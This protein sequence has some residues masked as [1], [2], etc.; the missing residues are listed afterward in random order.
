VN[1]N[2]R[3]A[4]DTQ[5]A[6]LISLITS[7][8]QPDSWDELG[9]PGTYTYVKD[10]GCLVIRQTWSVHRQILRLLRNLREIQH[11]APGGNAAPPAGDRKT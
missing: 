9:G 11:L 7:T 4:T 2:K 6:K 3:Y 8:I 5:E 1:V 10:T